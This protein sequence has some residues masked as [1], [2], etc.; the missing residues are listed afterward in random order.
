[1]GLILFPVFGFFLKPLG[2]T[3]F[4]SG[5]SLFVYTAAFLS[6]SGILFGVYAVL[7]CFTS[8]KYNPPA[9]N[10]GVKQGGGWSGVKQEL[11]AS[12][13][14]ISAFA[15]KLFWNF[16]VFKWLSVPTTIILNGIFTPAPI[17]LITVGIYF[18]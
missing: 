2:R 13:V 1:M 6:L 8:V 12:T 14:L 15:A 16:W 18:Q 3:F 10:E 11:F 9:H 5:T 7:D 4:I 17:L